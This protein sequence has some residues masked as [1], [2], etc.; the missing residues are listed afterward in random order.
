[1]PKE[2]RTQEQRILD[3]LQERGERGVMVWEFM[4]PR[5]QGG[6]GIAQ[7]SSR[8]FGLR[9]K[10]YNIQSDKQG[11]FTLVETPQVTFPKQKPME[12]VAGQEGMAFCV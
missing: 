2:S 12:Q 7:Y 9:H 3:L 6:L 1:M 4:V 11:K 10:G 8:I 5:P